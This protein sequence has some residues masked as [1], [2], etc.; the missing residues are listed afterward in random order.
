M[1]S[2]GIGDKGQAV[3]C[4]FCAWEG[5]RVDCSDPCPSCEGQVALGT[6]FRRHAAK[7]PRPSCGVVGVRD[8]GEEAA[9]SDLLRQ[10]REDA[11]R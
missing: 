2:G 3:H 9:T 11:S 5:S 1:G 10:A 7:L 8:P 6:Q 4:T